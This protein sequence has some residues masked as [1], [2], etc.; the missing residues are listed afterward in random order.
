MFDFGNALGLSPSDRLASAIEMARDVAETSGHAVSCREWGYAAVPS[1]GATPSEV[2]A[3][4][5]AVGPLP[6]D[7]REFLLIIRYLELDSGCSV[8]GCQ[9]EGVVPI[10]PP[11]RR[12]LL[13][14]D[15]LVFADYW[16]DADG[17]KLVFL[18]DKPGQPVARYRHEEGPRLVPFA[19]TFS[20][21]LWRMVHEYPE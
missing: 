21:A 7:Y 10:A 11:S 20:L 16:L 14:H 5:A 8:G 3:L 15:C 12:G 1:G 9:A 19:D 2:S 13:G 4:E 18:L 6:P 17:D